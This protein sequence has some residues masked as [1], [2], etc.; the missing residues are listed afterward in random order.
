[1]QTPRD[2][3]DKA[4]R[5]FSADVLAID[6]AAV[7]DIIGAALKQQV[8]GTLRRKGLVVGISGGIDS[9]VVAALATHALGTD[10][11]F[12]LFMP[13]RDSSGDSLRLGQLLA[14]TLGIEA[15][16]EELG[17]ALDGIG[18]YA[19]QLE[20][21]RAVFPDYGDGWKC[22]ITLP[23]VLESDRISISSLTVQDPDGKLST[24]RMPPAA[25]RQLVAATNYK[26]RM[27]KMAEYYHAD[28]LAYAVSGTPNRLEYDQGFFVKQGDG[29]ADVKPIA[30]L[31]KTQVY[32]LARHLGVPAEICARPPTTDTYSLEQTQEEFYFALPYDKMDLCLYA[33]DHGVSAEEAAPA[34]GVT[35]QQVERVFKDIE[36]KR[37]ASVYLHSPPLFVEAVG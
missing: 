9:A 28:R 21:L 34:V 1:M 2:D 5:S 20:A 8:L 16:V 15:I 4:A 29:A 14:E 12:G 3:A 22:K 24:A 10:R 19:R 35:P 26:Q 6:A 30:H 11:V 18:C 23:S 7:T 32:A 36:A 17:P 37:R 25:Y 13:E 31:Y 27:R 33:V